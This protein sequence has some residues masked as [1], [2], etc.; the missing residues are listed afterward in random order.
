[1]KK[2]KKQK[3]IPLQKLEPR[4]QINKYNMILW[5][6]FL[7]A[8][9]TGGIRLILGETWE[10]VNPGMFG[11]LVAFLTGI[12][13]CIVTEFLKEHFSYAGFLLA[14][15]WVFCV[16]YT[17]I[18]G[19]MDGAR[20]WCN[21]L[22]TRWNT[23]HE[24]GTALFN[25]QTDAHAINSLTVLMT[26]AS[27]ELLWV[28]ISGYHILLANLL[29][30]FWM[31]VQLIC[32]V[33][34]PLGCGFFFAGL[35]GLW[36]TEKKSSP[37]LRQIVWTGGILAAATALAL[38][39]PSEEILSIRDMRE[40]A[41]ETVYRIRYGENTLPEGNLY[42]SSELKVYDQ[43][44]LK[45]DTEQN[46]TL[47]LKGFTG[48]VYKD[49]IWK[50]QPDSAYGGDYTGM[51]KWLKEKGFDPIDQVAEY[52]SC[53]DEGKIP[54]SNKISVAV[55]GATRYYVYAPSS[56][57][58]ITKGKAEEQKDMGLTGK[59]LFG[60]K[61][62]HFNE[63][64]SSRPGELTVADSWVSDP[65]TDAQ[66]EYAE[67]EAVYRSFVYDNYRTV[68]Q[69]TRDLIQQMFWDDYETESDGIYSA[70]TH[71]RDVLKR[72]VQYTDYPEV[73]PEGEDPVIWFLT[74]SREGNAVLY[75]SAAVDALRV[76]GIPARYAEGY[77]ISSSDAEEA[78]GKNIS[79][80]GENTH[81]WV[82]AYFDGIGW[83]PLDVTPGY[84]YDA[85]ALQKMVSTP[86]VVQ[87]NA[88]LNDNSF[89]AEEITGLEGEHRESIGTKVLPV[90][91]D[92]GAI[93]LGIVALLLI[94]LV[95]GLT[96]CEIVRGYCIWHTERSYKKAS[97]EERILRIEKG[98]YSWMSLVGIEA[99]LGWNTK[100]T[101]QLLAERFPEVE[102]GEYSR[103]CE[104]IEKVIYGGLGLEP[105][106]VRTLTSFFGKLTEIG[107]TGDIRYRLILRYAFAWK[108]R[109]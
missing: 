36:I 59:G 24:G 102:P 88:I 66:K 4:G 69:D 47:Y 53:N 22:I 109:R 3:Q 100:E 65:Q 104:L 25:V 73:V 51:L 11:S 94:L 74:E 82:E 68:D 101:D 99:H 77:Y 92:V 23:I 43:E 80:T 38:L 6:T 105:F 29:F 72:T 55:T 5:W 95:L 33:I 85:V 84:Y 20:V 32:G 57:E 70:I 107:R 2:K 21:V 62:Y 48:A 8:L 54:E 50:P 1:M 40:A 31:L 42:N 15:P 35:G 27:V 91:R 86:D 93:C 79:V 56:L 71:I 18:S 7:T 83:L 39:M 13:V 28:L 37:V 60:T 12:A 19:G 81:A 52:Y 10:N 16:I 106:E 97:H 96:G 78:E 45:V 9:M 63:I 58:K 64:S 98:I 44:M 67:A 103:V 26:L 49:G 30:L 17:G 61:E 46:K 108:N 34:N 14:V 41:E 87:K 89:R 75:A 90:V 76:H